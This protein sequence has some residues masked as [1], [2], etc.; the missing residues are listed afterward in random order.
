MKV[1]VA[2]PAQQHSYRLAAALFHAGFLDH[3]A[4]TVYYKPWSLTALSARVLTGP[5]REKARARRCATLPD[6]RVLQ[7]CEG[8]G[9][10]KLLTMHLPVL[11]RWYR[12]VK[13]HGADRF[14]RKVV[15]YAV[16]HQVDA[17]VGYDDF[18]SLLFAQ[19]AEKA[20]EILRIMDVSAANVLYMRQIY[21]K[22]FV[23]QPAFA[24]RLRAERQIVW[25]PDTIARTKLEIETSQIFLAPSQFVATSLMAS[26][27]RAEQIRL[28]PYGVD[29]NEFSLK[30]YPNYNEIKRPLRFI[31]VGGVKE[32]KGISYLLQ[33]I[34][35]LPK[36]GAEL[37]VVGSA[38]SSAEALRPYRDRVRFTGMVLHSQIPELLRQ[39]DVFVFPS[40]GDSFAL[41]VLEAASCGLP[42]IVSENTGAGD[43]L[44][45]GTEGFVVPIQSVS[46]L[47]GKMQ[48]FLDH[49]EQIEPMGRAA[50][51]MAER[52]SWD[53][54]TARVG[55]VFRELEE[56]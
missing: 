8:E 37:I 17:V 11:R 31:Y 22:D 49:P 13:Y 45:D 26:G 9:L 24:E 55:T 41:S 10:L 48:Y 1:L 51:A 15:S 16:R 29:G 3:Y 4:T 40:L 33:A 35:R 43:L 38:D 44:T 5:M 36:D 46:A 52:N 21:E 30:T 39:A 18:S 25:D 2:H 28:C 23:L 14:A 34:A 54:Y 50:R 27:V 32:L 19:L 42:V 7:F 53:A 20:P 56:L 47:E 6:D 12:R